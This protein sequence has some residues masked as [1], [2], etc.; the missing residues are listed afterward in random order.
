[1]RALRWAVV[2]I[3]AAIAL[4]VVPGCGDDKPGS[5]DVLAVGTDGGDVSN[6]VADAASGDVA[7][8]T[9]IAGSSRI[10]APAY[11]YP[12]PAW[13]RIIAAAPTVG[14]MVANPADGPGPVADPH[15]FHAWFLSTVPMIPGCSTNS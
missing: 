13:E 14:I 12:G 8:L 9:V 7:P 1:M 15:S 10:I 5:P 2:M 3:W 11:I 4:G 6:G